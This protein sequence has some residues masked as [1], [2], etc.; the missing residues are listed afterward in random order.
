MVFGEPLRKNISQDIFDINIKTSSID[1]E[2]ITEVI[3]SG[4]AD[5]IVDQKK[6][7]AQTANKL[8]SKYIPGM[9]PV[10]H[11]LSFYRWLPILTQFNALRLKTD[12]KKLVV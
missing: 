10:G 8:Y 5:D 4:K 7:L 11:P 3:L 2:V 6:Q 12:L 9:M 1:A